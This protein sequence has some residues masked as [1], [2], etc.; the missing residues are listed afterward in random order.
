[1]LLIYLLCFIINCKKLDVSEL[2]KWN[3][4]NVREKVNIFYGCPIRK[5]LIKMSKII[6]INLM[7]VN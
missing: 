3:I 1:M 6:S 4:D 7:E 5:K 2:T